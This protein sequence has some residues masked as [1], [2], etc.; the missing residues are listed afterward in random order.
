MPRWLSDILTYGVG[1]LITIAVLG[2]LRRRGVA[3]REVALREGRPTSFEAF[4]RGSAA[5]YPRRWRFGWVSV[6]LGG[7]TWKPRFSF[8][9]RSIQ[10][11][12]HATIDSIRRPT[13]FMESLWTNPGC[14]IA[15]VR[16]GEVKLE[17]AIVAADVPTSLE[18]LASGAGAHWSFGDRHVVETAVEV[19]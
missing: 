8:A 14:L 10:L 13:G 6:N 17:L 7:P 5:P 2:Y 1:A 19:E 11:P 16:A 12:T 3:R 9:R 4:L 18:S 15:V